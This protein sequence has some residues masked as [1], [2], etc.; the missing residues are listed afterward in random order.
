[1]QANKKN[2]D[3][4]GS[5]RTTAPQLSVDGTRKT[6]G[7]NRDLRVTL[8][9]GEPDLAALTSVVT[10]WLV[11]LLVQQFFN[12]HDVDREVSLNKSSTELRGKE[13]AAN[14]RIR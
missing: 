3:V 11:P 14:S 1:M 5:L 2:V 7:M 8:S 10:E 4:D 13:G 9:P 12:Q 6:K